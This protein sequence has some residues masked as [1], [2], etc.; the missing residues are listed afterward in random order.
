MS[1]EDVDL[2]VDCN[3]FLLNRYIDQ[4]IAGRCVCV[5]LGIAWCERLKYIHTCEHL[6]EDRIFTVELIGR[7]VGDEEL[8]AA[9]IG[10]RVDHGDHAWTAKR[11]RGQD[12][13]DQIIT[14]VAFACP[15][16]IAGLS[17]ELGDYTM[18]SNIV[19]PAAFCQKNK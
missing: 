14:G 5:Q 10:T 17:V 6:S 9:G 15:T 1:R 7:R 8:S 19:I 13:G 11:Q 16:G 2:F 4:L 18:K 3:L 12:L